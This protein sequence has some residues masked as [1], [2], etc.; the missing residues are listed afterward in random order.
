[1]LNPFLMHLLKKKIYFNFMC[2]GVLTAC[3]SAHHGI[4]KV[5][6]IPLE[7]VLKKVLSY[8]VGLGIKHVS[9]ARTAVLLV[10]KPALQPP[11]L[12]FLEASQQINYASVVLLSENTPN[13]PSS[14]REG[15]AD[16]SLGY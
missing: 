8:H 2:T 9:P 16:P 4:Q 11:S 15:S 5:Y 10:T 3:V 14:T 13:H 6:H 1:M 7:Q 12:I